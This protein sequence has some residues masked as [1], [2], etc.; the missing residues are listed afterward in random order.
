VH[1]Q[2]HRQ[3]QQ[4]AAAARPESRCERLSSRA[5]CKAAKANPP[6]L[7]E[8]STSLLRRCLSEKSLVHSRSGKTHQPGRGRARNPMFWFQKLGTTCM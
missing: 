8:G 1:E 6:R 7:V 3:R 4:V 2:L 5:A